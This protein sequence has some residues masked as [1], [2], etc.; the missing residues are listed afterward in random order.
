[1]EKTYTLNDVAQM[2][3]FT[4]RTLRTYISQGLLRGKKEDGKWQFSEEEVYAF[5]DEPFVKEGIRIKYSSIVF[6]FLADRKKKTER[7]C[8]VL[9]IP[10]SFAEGNRVSAFF[11]GEMEKRKDLVFAYHWDGGSCRVILSG[12]LDEAAKVIEAYHAWK[13]AE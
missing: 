8:T 3:G 9:D 1:M 7:A 5:F 6:D 11:C 12:A 10:A 4:T 13:K 2:T